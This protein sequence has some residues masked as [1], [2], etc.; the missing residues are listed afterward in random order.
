MFYSE[1]LLRTIAR[2]GSLSDSS[3]GLFQRFKRGAGIYRNSCWKKKNHE[4]E[5]QK[6]TANHKKTDISS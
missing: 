6:I 5:H 2:D 1:A 4:V 3:E